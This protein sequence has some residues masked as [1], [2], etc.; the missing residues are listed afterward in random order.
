[1]YTNME[2]WRFTIYIPTNYLLNIII[3]MVFDVLSCICMFA[4]FVGAYLI[5]GV[6]IY[7]IQC[8]LVTHDQ[9][10]NVLINVSYNFNIQCVNAFMLC[11]NIYSQQNCNSNRFST[12][13]K[14]HILTTMLWLGVCVCVCVWV[15]VCVC[16]CVS[17]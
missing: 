6:C 7:R 4:I 9:D 10:V 13:I 1:M 16:E 14:N 11:N 15:C 17:V 5:E 3:Y 8:I 12:P 2:T